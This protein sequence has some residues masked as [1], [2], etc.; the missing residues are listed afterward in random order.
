MLI[1]VRPTLQGCWYLASAVSIPSTGVFQEGPVLLGKGWV[2]VIG[3]T[4][5]VGRLG[6]WLGR[7]FLILDFCS[8]R[9]GPPGS[10]A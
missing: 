3:W 2:W 9:A 10:W 6:V 8:R 7:E 5:D 1:K 4:V